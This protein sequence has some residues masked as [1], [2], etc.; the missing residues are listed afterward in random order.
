MSNFQPSQTAGAGELLQTKLRPPHLAATLVR[1]QALFA[2]LDEGLD[3]TPGVTLLSAPAGFGKT[4]LVSQWL[5][6]RGQGSGSGDQRSGAGGQGSGVRETTFGKGFRAAWVSLDG[7]DNDPVRFWRYV[8]TA[9]QVFRPDLGG[10]GLE[11]L[12]TSRQPPF[13]VMLTAFLNELTQL[14]HRSLLVLEDYHL[15]TS[16]QIHQAV[17]FFLDHLPA[18][19][20]LVMLTRSDPPLP[21]ARLRARGALNELRSADLRFTPAETRAF[22]RQALLL[23][24]SAEAIARLESRTEG[25]AAGLRLAALALQGR[26]A[27]AEMEQFL[28]TFAGSHRHVLEYLAE[29]VL[30]VQPEP[31]Q[32]FL[33]QTTWLG[34]LTAALADAVTGQA[35]S[36]AILEELERMNL[37]LTPLDGARQWYRYHA[38]F[39][40]AMQHEARHR[41][42]AAELAALYSRASHS[43]E[44]HGFL[45]EA[46]ESALSSGAF[47]RAA[48]L[49]DRI[50]GPGSFYEEVHTLRRWLE[51]LPEGVLAAYPALCLAYAMT[52]LFTG[53]RRAPATAVVVERPLRLAEQGW[54]AGDN[55]PKLGEVLTFR[56][57]VTWWQ[58]DMGQ[59][60]GLARQALELLPEA[61]A[62]WRGIALLHR[63]MEE[64]LAG[65]LHQ[66]RQTLL[67]S[68]DLSETAGNAH[69]VMAATFVL[70]EVYAG[71]GDLHQAAELQ[72]QVLAEAEHVEVG[73]PLE[74]KA[75]ALLNLAA[76]AYEWNDLERAETYA[77]QA[78]DIGRQLDQEYFLENGSLSLAKIKHAGGQRAAA[79]QMLHALFAQVRKPLLLRQVQ[80]TL[81]RLALAAG[82]TTTV[83]RWFA[84]YIS[85]GEEAPL[86]QQEQ[87]AFLAFRIQI[88]RGEAEQALSQL[89]DWQAGAAAQGRGRT[90]LE[91]R[92]LEALAHAATADLSQAKEKLHQALALALPQGYRRLFLDEGPP[93]AALLGATLPELP[94]GPLA[95]YGRALL[96]AFGD[97]CCP[98][99]GLPEPAAASLVEPLSVQEQRVLRLLA[100]GLSNPEIAGELIV[101][102]NTV[103]TQVQSI[104]RKFDVHS[105]E[106]ASEVAHRL[107]L[108]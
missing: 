87:E 26:Q 90:I 50:L 53:D 18:T 103:K 104:Y 77:G 21:L 92:V 9:C 67:E 56:A 62:F 20:H 58:G 57:M 47:D 83:Q 61:A 106:D 28:A 19:L 107:K 17:T 72:R 3:R 100:A 27:P 4:T 12:H 88:G 30:A 81:A 39:A 85:S 10:A 68:R 2:R 93:L 96:D 16:P 99:T 76:L 37:F 14:P 24:L 43:Y 60:F 38:L 84:T 80:A 78:L 82:D 105:R 52:L 22:L 40:E 13:E 95:S 48:G 64:R 1:R 31:L 91:L 108:L 86:Y 70:G 23:P 89:E 44:T 102:V 7:G 98:P 54:L 46:I 33:M 41:L 71:Q 74:D 29:E 15:I 32:Q 94:A 63:G 59:S 65:R 25:W 75:Q 101:S 6:A 45:P 97:S 69:G 79:L 11:L 73:E 5:E 51:G 36:Q 66:A 8:L 35:G 55:R 42:G 49:I 34:R